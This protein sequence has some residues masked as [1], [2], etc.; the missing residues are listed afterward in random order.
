MY[1]YDI[2]GH[3]KVKTLENK[4]RPIYDALNK[5]FGISN[6]G[7]F[8]LMA[9]YA[10]YSENVDLEQKV[11]TNVNEE[12]PDS[13]KEKLL[14]I[15]YGTDSTWNNYLNATILRLAKIDGVSFEQAL[16]QKEIYNKYLDKLNIYAHAAS[17][18][19]L[20]NDLNSYKKGVNDNNSHNFIQ[21]M[22]SIFEELEEST[23]F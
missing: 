2:G 19:L 23:P 5:Y 21:D 1:N 20:K 11:E 18:Y 22:L 13:K 3:F 12:V 7:A 4:G 16:G 17:S 14:Q 10:I 15:R 9:T 8:I 6:K